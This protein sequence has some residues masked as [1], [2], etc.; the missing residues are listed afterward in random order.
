MTRI[1]LLCGT[2][3]SGGLP[4]VPPSLAYYVVISRFT[5][6]VVG[7]PVHLSYHI[8]TPDTRS[9]STALRIHSGGKNTK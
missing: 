5:S 4:S 9:K 1:V 3:G 2:E 8:R 7:H 6:Y